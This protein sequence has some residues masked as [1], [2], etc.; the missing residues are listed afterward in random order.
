MASEPGTPEEHAYTLSISRDGK[1][2]AKIEGISY[3]TAE[4]AFPG[5]LADHVAQGQSDDE[6]VCAHAA[7]RWS[8][9]DDNST[10][11]YRGVTADLYAI[12]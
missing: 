10:L 1:V 7:A 3:R 2:L 9:L 11:T 4:T 8:D 6:Q 5:M 12:D